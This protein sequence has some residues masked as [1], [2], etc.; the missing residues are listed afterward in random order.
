[1]QGIKRKG[2]AI[3][4]SIQSWK[5]KTQNNTFPSKTGPTLPDIVSSAL[6]DSLQ[7]KKIEHSG[8]QYFPAWI[9]K[10]ADTSWHFQKE[11]QIQLS[12]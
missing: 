11:R 6:K 12:D 3:A 2:R 9:S 1:M 7:K 8:C 10:L 4:F 5:N